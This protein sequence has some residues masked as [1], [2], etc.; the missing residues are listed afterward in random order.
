MRGSLCLHHPNGWPR[1]H[2]ARRS[3]CLRGLTAGMQLFIWKPVQSARRG[4]LFLSEAGRPLLTCLAPA[5]RE[6]GRA[7]WGCGASICTPSVVWRGGRGSALGLARSRWVFPDKEQVVPVVCPEQLG[8]DHR[9]LEGP[10]R[11]SPRD[12]WPQLNPGPGHAVPAP[13]TSCG[14]E[15]APV[16][17]G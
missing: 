6:G 2:P 9:S 13:R 1:R 15:G 11:L 7:Q 10:F 14:H 16:S 3:G 12:T 17:L 8:S 4:L 5:G